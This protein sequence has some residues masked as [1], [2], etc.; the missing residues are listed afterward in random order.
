MKMERLPPNVTHK[1][2]ADESQGEK[3]ERDP[4]ETPDWSEVS[5]SCRES[6]SCINQ[7]GMLPDWRASGFTD[8]TLK[9]S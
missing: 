4:A 1:E 8:V 6:D 3:Y 7:D 9:K 2:G 5:M